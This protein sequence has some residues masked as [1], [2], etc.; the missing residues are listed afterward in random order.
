MHR[1]ENGASKVFFSLKNSEF[2]C[3]EEQRAQLAPTYL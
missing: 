2:D 1:N 3:I